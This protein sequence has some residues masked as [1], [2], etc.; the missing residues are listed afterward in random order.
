LA[1]QDFWREGAE[2][3]ARNNNKT[4]AELECEKIAVFKLR[5][6]LAK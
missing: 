6:H 2:L 4:S 3:K 5:A 1:Y